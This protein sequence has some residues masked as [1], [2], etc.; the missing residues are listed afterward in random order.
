M[1]KKILENIWTEERG[2]NWSVEEIGRLEAV[3]LIFLS[4]NNQSTRIVR[5]KHRGML[6]HY[7]KISGI[8]GWAV[9]K[10]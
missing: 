9:L 10:I 2:Y 3:Q 6:G 7:Y 1:I 4:K 5:V 8:Y